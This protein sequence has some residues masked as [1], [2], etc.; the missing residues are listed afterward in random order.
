ME[1][2]ND[3]SRLRVNSLDLIPF[4]LV[5]TATT[6]SQIIKLRFAAPHLRNNVIYG[7]PLSGDAIQT[8][9][10]LASLPGAF[11]NSLPLSVGDARLTHRLEL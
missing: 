6:Q 8:S 9:A 10:I 1:E 11:V 5:T 2:R 3:S 7:K 4:V